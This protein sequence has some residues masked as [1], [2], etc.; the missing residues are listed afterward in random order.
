MVAINLSPKQLHSSALIPFIMRQLHNKNVKP[1]WIEFEI[2]ESSIISDLEHSVEILTKLK[3]IGFGLALDDFGTGYSSLSY[4][5]KLP[6][7]I[8]KIDKSFVMDLGESRRA[9]SVVETILALARSLGLES[10]AEGIE[11][12]EHVRFLQDLKCEYGQG[13]HFSR[14]LTYP[15]FLSLIDRKKGGKVV[16]LHGV[17]R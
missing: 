7:D 5:T 9:G 6:I 15:D 16:N 1:E 14:P 17:D 11:K 12:E 8:L 13:Y 4:L 2:T 3:S 10:T